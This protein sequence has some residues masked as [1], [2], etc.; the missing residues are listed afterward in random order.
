MVENKVYLD[1][2]AA[3]PLDPKVLASMQPYFVD[4]FYNPSANYTNAR[5]IS[6]DIK[7]ARADVAK[8]LSI[9]PEEIFFTAG[10]TEANNLAISGIMEANPGKK[11]IISAIEH[12]SIV[13][14][15]HKYNYKIAPVD[16]TGKVIISEL[17]KL[18]DNDTVLVSVMY[19]NNE[20]GTIQPLTKIKQLIT[21]VRQKRQEMGIDLPL[22]FHTDGCQ[23]ANYLSLN[24]AGLGLDL[25]TLNGGKIYGPK[26]SGILFIH[27]S[28]EL[29]PQILGGGQ[30]RGIRSG[31]ENVPSIIGFSEALKIAIG[32]KQEES[33]RLEKLR[34]YFIEKLETSGLNYSINGSLKNRLPNNLNLSFD[35]QDNETLL[36][37]LDQEGIMCSTGSACSAQ[38]DTIS[39][40]LL[41][42]GLNEDQALS[43][44]RFSFGRKT[45]KKQIDYTV[46]ILQKILS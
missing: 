38:K 45:T 22:Y 40:T 27:R 33:K 20:I 14:P 23:A 10:G 41:A 32:M 7:N 3:T 1:Y 8:I 11:L 4:K 36:Y 6:S 9:K 42:I 13:D 31:T 44:L 21:A 29:I 37:K 17:E 12:E 24:A 19:A 43:S 15:A 28:V 25:M 34:N 26:Q 16:K 2:A 5:E 39:A 18:I 30:E 35:G 46:M